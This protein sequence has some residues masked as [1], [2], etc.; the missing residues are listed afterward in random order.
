MIIDVQFVKLFSRSYYGHPRVS[1]RW[2]NGG[3]P[4]TGFKP[5]QSSRRARTA[6]LALYCSYAYQPVCIE[7][8][9]LSTKLVG[10]YYRIIPHSTV[11]Y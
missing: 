9:L 6:S 5:T 2:L 8:G 1:A 3:Q 7:S 4:A 11:L 10:E